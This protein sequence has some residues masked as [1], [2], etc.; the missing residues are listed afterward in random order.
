MIIYSSALLFA[1]ALVVCFPFEGYKS[2]SRDEALEK[3]KHLPLHDFGITKHTN[4]IIKN[5]DGSLSTYKLQN[6]RQALHEDSSLT[7]D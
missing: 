5:K 3:L 6:I 2:L 4:F 1:N 7:P